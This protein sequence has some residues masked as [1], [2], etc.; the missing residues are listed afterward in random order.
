MRILV[1]SDETKIAGELRDWLGDNGCVASDVATVEDAPDA[2]LRFKPDAVFVVLDDLGQF[3]GVAAE[4]SDSTGARLIAVGPAA[5]A[6]AILAVQREG[7][8]HFVDRDTL[9]DD[10]GV[11]LRRLRNE[12]QP[13]VTRGRLI[14]VVST[15]GGSGASTVAVNV[16]T[17]LCKDERGCALLD[18][19][20]RTGDLASLLQLRPKNSVAD[21]CKNLERMDDNM[22]E[23]CMCRHSSGVRLL[24][25][26]PAMQDIPTISRRGIRRL[27]AMSR[28]HFPYV[29]A[30]VHSVYDPQCFQVL[31]QSEV[32]VLVMR[33]DF[34]S[35]SQT[36]RLVDHLIEKG[37]PKSRLRII[38][39]RYRRFA[40]LKPQR[41][42][43]VLGMKLFEI[44]PDQ[45]QAVSRANNKGVP[46]VIEKPRSTVSRRLRS[47]AKNVNGAM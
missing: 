28:L 40:D 7:G 1:V 4:L 13:N 15:S 31:Q 25:R 30:D 47:V 38:M 46:I 37:V 17:S 24:S 42:E 9:L 35:L 3:G 8:F 29:V 16:A 45:P 21:F 18:L 41:I 34:S 43:E 12:P 10:A 14:C 27:V 32:I 22:F 2:A 33:P 23:K 6:K 19:N 11:V 44:I 5:D 20:F 26:P 39:N 36:Q